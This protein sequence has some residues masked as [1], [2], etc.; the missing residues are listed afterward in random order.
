MTKGAAL[1]KAKIE[2]LRKAPSNLAHPYFWAGM[3]L[4]GDSQAVVTTKN[5]LWVMA[6]MGFGIMLVGGLAL[7]FLLRQT[8]K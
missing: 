5:N 1:Q 4:V 7:R 8:T 6:G 3:T 2:Y